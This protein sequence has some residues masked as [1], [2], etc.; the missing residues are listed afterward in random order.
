MQY[1]SWFMLG[2]AAFRSD[3]W[4][5]AVKAFRVCTNLDPEVNNYRN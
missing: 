5:T 3:K 4:S 1:D 2:S